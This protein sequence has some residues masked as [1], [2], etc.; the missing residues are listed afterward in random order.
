MSC[1]VSFIRN[2]YN[3]LFCLTNNRIYPSNEYVFNNELSE[4]IVMQINQA[5]LNEKE[6]I[7]ENQI[8]ENP[9]INI[10]NSINNRNNKKSSNK[11]SSNK[12][13]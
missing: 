11:K 10:H 8:N 4:S 1:I 3:R 7:Y 5:D 12:K 13:N 9:S 6:Y 2:N